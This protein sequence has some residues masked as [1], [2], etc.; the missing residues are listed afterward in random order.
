MIPQL[1][2][3]DTLFETTVLFIEDWRKM[4]SVFAVALFRLTTMFEQ[5]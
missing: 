4:P 5:K 3:A 2:F 1:L